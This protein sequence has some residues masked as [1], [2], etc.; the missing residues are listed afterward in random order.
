MSYSYEITPRPAELG[1][2]WRLRLLDG[3]EE[4]GGGVFPIDQ[5]RTDPQQGI[6]WWNGLQEAERAWWL[7]QAVER[8]AVGTAAE[9]YLSYLLIEAHL[10]AE[11]T[12]QEW[13][14]SRP[15]E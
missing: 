13:I 8:G 1:G 4:M 7:K 6:D 3:T 14:D 12:A 15:S 5:E 10:D 11:A 2:G 9:A